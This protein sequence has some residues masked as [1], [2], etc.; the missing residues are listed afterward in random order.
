MEREVSWVARRDELVAKLA[1][2]AASCPG[3]YPFQ[4]AADF[5][6]VAQDQAGDKVESVC[7]FLEAMWQ[8]PEEAVQLNAQSLIRRGGGFKKAESENRNSEKIS[9]KTASGA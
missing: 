5:L 6:R 4:E 9:G 8:R 7:R 2:R 1:Q 3:L